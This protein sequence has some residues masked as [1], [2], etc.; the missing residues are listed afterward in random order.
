MTCSSIDAHMSR[1]FAYHDEQVGLF[2]LEDGLQV[3]VAAIGR[4]VVQATQGGGRGH[5]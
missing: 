5:A 3:G 4:G 1:S 2:L